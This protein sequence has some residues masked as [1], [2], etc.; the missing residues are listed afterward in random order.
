MTIKL[1]PGSGEVPENLRQFNF[2]YTVTAT[3]KKYEDAPG[4]IVDIA[5]Q[6]VD[7]ERNPISRVF[8]E[9]AIED[10]TA[11]VDFIELGYY[12]ETYEGT[13]YY[14]VVT[15]F[16]ETE[17]ESLYYVNPEKRFYEWEVNKNSYRKESHLKNVLVETQDWLRPFTVSTNAQTQEEIKTYAPL[18]TPF[19][20]TVDCGERVAVEVITDGIDVN[21]Y[22]HSD[23]NNIT[24]GDLY[25]KN[26]R[27][28]CTKR[29]ISAVFNDTEGGGLFSGL[30]ADFLNSV[31]PTFADFNFYGEFLFN[32]SVPTGSEE[33]VTLIHPEGTPLSE[34]LIPPGKEGI[35]PDT[36][37]NSGDPPPELEDYENRTGGAQFV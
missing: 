18:P 26:T 19:I 25:S 23:L 24:E 17:Y 13:N 1:T 22:N 9:Y 12:D 31:T 6:T 36:F 2:P 37:W 15:S 35:F 34:R 28:I 10:N 4:N 29:Y 16:V 5:E 32:F 27:I 14:Q 30:L 11:F 8:R 3:N 20:L 21:I 33:I 7:I